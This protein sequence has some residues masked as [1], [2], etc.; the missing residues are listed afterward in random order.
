[1]ATLDEKGIKPRR[2]LRW[3]HR[4]G[5]VTTL[6]IAAELLAIAFFGT[7][8]WLENREM[9]AAR[10]EYSRTHE[11]PLR[12]DDNGMVHRSATYLLGQ[13]PPLVALHGDGLR[14]VAMPSF[15]KAHFAI[16]ISLPKP[17]ASEAGGIVARF[18]QYNRY[19][20]LGQRRFR[21]PASAYRSLTAKLDAL[22]D[23]WPGKANWC[24]DGTPTAFERVRGTRV[25]SGIGNCELH[26]EHVEQLM[27]NYMQRFAPGDDLPTGGG[28]HSEAARSR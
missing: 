8:R 25:T 7:R 16:A 3:V 22:T 18:D 15:N 10:I 1:M 14:F 21:L 2:W 20:P 11:G 12:A 17:N 27:W 6:L 28:W 4:V 26:Y 23:G 24:A 5:Y 19:A 9:R 13:L